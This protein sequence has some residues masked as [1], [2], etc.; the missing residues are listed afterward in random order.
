MQDDNNLRIL[1]TN[2]IE[3]IKYVN[4]GSNLKQTF[5]PRLKQGGV[6]RAWRSISDMY[7]SI[8]S[9][10]LLIEKTLANKKRYDLLSNFDYNIINSIT[11][12]TSIFTKIFNILEKTTP[13]FI[14]SYPVSIHYKI[15]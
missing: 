14:W 5:T 9:N 10:H 1:H 12:I 8:D 2:I 13:I 15:I 6:T 11:K 4:K 7:S 3:I